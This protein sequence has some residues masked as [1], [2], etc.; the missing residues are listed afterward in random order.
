MLNRGN[1]QAIAAAVQATE[2]G[3]GGVA[4]DI[5]FGGGVG[6]RLLLDGVGQDGVVHGIELADDMLRRAG[7]RFGTDVQSGRLRLAHGSLT[8]IPL[9]DEALDAL[10]TV[11]TI[12]FVD[13]LD[14]VCAELARVVRPGGRAVV[15][16][17]DP[18]TMARLPFTS[19][20]FM[21]RPVAEVV[22]TLQKSGFAEVEDQRLDGPPMPRYLLVARR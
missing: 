20:G 9:D 10:V 3:L 4:A 6:L 12:Y 8:A 7:A 2:V 21:L 17:G 19:H 5:G 16:V 14:A 18:E 13:N 15:G 1:A 11:N 22:A